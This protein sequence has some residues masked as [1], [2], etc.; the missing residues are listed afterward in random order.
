[1]QQQANSLREVEQER[2]IC[3]VIN[4]REVGMAVSCPEYLQRWGDLIYSVQ[5]A[6]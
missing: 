3:L 6:D 2:A 1:M 4:N 5:I